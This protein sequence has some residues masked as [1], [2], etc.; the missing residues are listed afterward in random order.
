MYADADTLVFVRELAEQ[1]LLVAARRASGRP[2][3][4]PLRTLARGLYEA[5][6]LQPADAMVTLPADGPSLRIWRLGGGGHG[7]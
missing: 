7:E 3:V 6:D 1:S 2:V 5:A 4:L